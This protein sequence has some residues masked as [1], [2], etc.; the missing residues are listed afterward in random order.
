MRDE[1]MTPGRDKAARTLAAQA[2]G[3]DRLLGIGILLTGALLVAGWT[4]PIMTVDRLLFLEERISILEACAALWSE[5]E[6]FLFAVIAVFSIVF[7]LLKLGAALYLWYR[8][9]AASPRLL[10]SL[11]WVETLGRWSMLDVFAVALAVV[12]IQISLI[13][14]VA[15]HAGIYVFTAA[16]VLSM[17]AVQRIVRL[18]RRALKD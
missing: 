7:P 18:A 10:H 2:Q 1:T 12:A 16:I 9:D 6:Y 11:T 8:A 17:L 15:I 3:A 4:L 5:G 14:D 13:S